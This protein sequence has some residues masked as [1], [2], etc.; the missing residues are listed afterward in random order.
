MTPNTTPIPINSHKLA[1][2]QQPSHTHSRM[3]RPRTS[4]EAVPWLLP[5]AHEADAEVLAE[6]LQDEADGQAWNGCGRV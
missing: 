5:V 2:K 6:E 1:Q 4:V 3:R